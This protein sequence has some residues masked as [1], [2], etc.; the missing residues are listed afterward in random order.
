[1][2]TNKKSPG[3]A[4]IILAAGSGSRMCADITKQRMLVLGKSVLFRAVNA[5]DSCSDID[6]LVIVGKACELDFIAEEIQGRVNKPYKIV[7]GGATRAE[8]ARCGFLAVSSDVGLVSIHDAARC[9]ITP[10][11]ISRVVEA[12]R[13]YGAAT[14]AVRVTDTVKTVDENGKITGNIPRDGLI[15][16]QTPQIFKWDWYMEALSYLETVDPASITD[17]NLLLSLSGRE[18]YSVIVGEYNLKITEQGDIARAELVLAERG[19]GNV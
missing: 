3:T 10:S 1:M 7:A 15:R 17:D 8:S 2:D 4:A 18:V 11:D 6:E 16:T 5:F 14:A 19:E 13:K 9:L 12:A